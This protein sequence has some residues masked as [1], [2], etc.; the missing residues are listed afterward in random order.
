MS[1]KNIGNRGVLEIL[2]RKKK[3]AIIA[4]SVAGIIV[5]ILLVFSGQ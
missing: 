2:N 3:L 4:V 5:G 1:V